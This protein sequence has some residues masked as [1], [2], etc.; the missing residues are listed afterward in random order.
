MKQKKYKRISII[1]SPGA[2]KTT[3]ANK[4]EKITGLPAYHLDKYYLE[5]PNYW[6]EH[7]LEWIDFVKNLINKEA[8]IIDG[9]YSKTF[10]ERFDIS[11]LIILLDVS[12]IKAYR[13]ILDRRLKYHKKHRPEMPDGWEEKLNKD[14]L[15]FVW[16]Y[17]NKNKMELKEKLSKVDSTKIVVLKSRSEIR[18]FMSDL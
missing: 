17:H 10:D 5:K 16:K 15:M 1:G 14:F 9:N 4:L 3:L 8:W 13:G 6:D 7:N 11:D 12:R 2:G 18:K